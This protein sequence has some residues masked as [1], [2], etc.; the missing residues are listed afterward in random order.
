M[1]HIAAAISAMSQ[2]EIGKFEADSKFELVLDGRAVELATEDVEIVSEDMPGWLVAS[3]GALTIALDVTITDALRSEGVAR[4]IVNRVQNLRKDSGL[5]V[6][7]RI[8]LRVESNSATDSAVERWRDY[9]A[10][11]TLSSKIEI[12]E[13]KQPQMIDIDGVEISIGIVCEKK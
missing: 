10:A 13:Q 5:N 3:E 11:Q 2:S 1:K 9:I 4:E 12:T 8:E 7:D 6:T